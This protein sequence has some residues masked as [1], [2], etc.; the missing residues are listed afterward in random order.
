MYSA[1]RTLTLTTGDVSSDVRHHNFQLGRLGDEAGEGTTNA[2]GGELGQSTQDGRR[3]GTRNV[4]GGSDRSVALHVHHG[5][6]KCQEEN[7]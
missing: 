5:K 4:D 2:L 7:V 3:K 1:T 6:E